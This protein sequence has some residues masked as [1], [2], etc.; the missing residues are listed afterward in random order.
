MSSWTRATVIRV[1]RAAHGVLD[2][3]LVAD[4]ASPLPEAAAG[5]HLDVRLPNGL[6]RQYSIHRYNAAVNSYSIGV[7]LSEPS[8]GGSAFIHERLQAG[9]VVE[10]G[11]ARNNFPIKPGAS[12]YLFVAGGIGI[13]PILSMV[14]WCDANNKPWRLLYCVRSRARAAYIEHLPRSGIVTLHVDDEQ[15]G[16]PNLHD[17]IRD[18]GADDQLYCCGPAPLMDAVRATAEH[19]LPAQHVHFELFSVAHLCAKPEG[20]EASF[21][22]ELARSGRE[23]TVP[24]T[25]S[26]LDVLEQ[27]GVMVPF[28]CR[29]GLCRTCECSVLDGEVDHRDYVLGDA[30]RDAN[31]VMLVCVS[32][33]KSK[34]LTLDL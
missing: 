33:A 8:R 3:E 12:T 32:R 17:F 28:S 26:V 22:I 19:Y 30:E 31:N 2:I 25:S 11:A 21:I 34:K 10:L 15:A 14:R 29:E 9:D 24:G 23:L 13:T 5:A 18:A 7:G 6:I 1:Q 4:K 27:A 20:E 16:H